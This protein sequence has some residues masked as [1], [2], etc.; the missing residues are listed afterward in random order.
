M[1]GVLWLPESPRWLVKAN[2]PED[3]QKVLN[4]I[5]NQEFAKSTFNDIEVSLRGNTRKHSYS[6]IF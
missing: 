5:G 4:K 2:R 1:Q 3:A 6:A